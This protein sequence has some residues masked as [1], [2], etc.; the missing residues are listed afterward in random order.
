MLIFS[1]PNRN[2]FETLLFEFPPPPP[3]LSPEPPLKPPLD[4]LFSL[5]NFL[6]YFFVDDIT[7]LLLWIWSAV[8]R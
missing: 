4:P 2:P 1:F 8:F 3:E 7:I 6:F 5:Q